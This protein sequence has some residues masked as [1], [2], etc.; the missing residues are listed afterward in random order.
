MPKAVRFGQDARLALLRGVDLSAAAIG[1]TLG[2]HGRG[3]LVRNPH[4]EQCFFAHDAAATA[5]TI[6]FRD[7]YANMGARLINEVAQKAREQAGDGAATAVVLAR[8]LMHGAL[9]Q[10]AAGASPVALRRGIEEAARTAVAAIRAQARPVATAEARLAVAVTAA[11]DAMVG[12]AVA[13]AID[14]VGPDGAVF[15]ETLPRAGIEV[16]RV[17]GWHY[18][19]GLASPAFVSS[20]Y[21]T[22]AVVENPWILLTDRKLTEIGDILPT[23]EAL[24]PV[25]HRDLVVICDGIEGAALG[26]MVANKNGGLF[27]CA[28][29]QPP[30]WQARRRDFMDDIAVY[31]GGTVISEVLGRRLDSVR[32]EDLGRAAR[33]EAT[34][35]RTVIVDGKGDPEAIANRCR[36]IRSDVELAHYEFDKQKFRERIARL[37][38]R[39]ALVKVGG[40]H[41]RE[42]KRRTHQAERALAVL[43]AAIADGVVPGG[44]IALLAAAGSPNGTA[45]DRDEALGAAVLAKALEAP[46]AWLARTNGR[47]PSTTVARVQ[48][49]RQLDANPAIGYDAA[50][51]EVGDLAA[52]GVLDPAGIVCAALECAV[53]GAVMLLSTEAVVIDTVPLPMPKSPGRVPYPAPPPPVAK[54]MT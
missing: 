44:G 51:D 21:G 2:P 54:G 25:V 15:V 11:G 31:T 18:D 42:V 30:D 10:L 3:V 43:K 36:L 47:E 53:S 13:A 27:N 50:R 35:E 29:V 17:N 49:A 40:R 52:R 45:A 5:E 46:L 39:V 16:E 41:E 22:K 1:Y 7:Q 26:L 34:S 48:A 8:A 20:R 9:A 38:G 19:R 12:E 32:I 4:T 33:V 28:V 14:M 6:D 24:T 23:F 37:E